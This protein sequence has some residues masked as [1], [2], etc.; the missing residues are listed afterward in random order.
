MKHLKK[1]NESSS[2][3][4]EMKLED[5]FVEFIDNGFTID[6]KLNAVT[7][8]YIG[9]YDFEEVLEMYNDVIIKLLT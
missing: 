7:L 9:K 5:Y 4:T 2:K 3:S 8:K 1:Y 6:I